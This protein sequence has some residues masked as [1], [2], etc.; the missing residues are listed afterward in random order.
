M[1][2]LDCMAERLSLNP[3]NLNLLQLHHVNYR[4]QESLDSGNEKENTVFIVFHI[5]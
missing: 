3:S 4:Q 2:V 5:A 1:Y